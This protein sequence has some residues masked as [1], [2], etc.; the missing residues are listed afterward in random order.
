[1]TSQAKKMGFLS[2]KLK[3]ASINIAC[4]CVSIID[5]NEDL[6]ILDL[7]LFSLNV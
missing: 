3:E 2:K 5:V 1:M 6:L 4:E 7:Y